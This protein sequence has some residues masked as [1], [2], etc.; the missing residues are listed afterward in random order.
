M[1]NTIQEQRNHRLNLK[2]GR[3]RQAGSSRGE[4]ARHHWPPGKG[5]VKPRETS[6]YPPERLRQ[7]PPPVPSFGNALAR[8]WRFLNRVAGSCKA[9]PA[10]TRGAAAGLLGLRSKA[11]E[12]VPTIHGSCTHEGRET[13]TQPTCSTNCSPPAQGTSPSHDQVWAGATG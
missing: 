2:M 4:G 12:H 3:R 13:R 5:K 6:A 9:K 8:C 10:L 11:P 1:R 7:R